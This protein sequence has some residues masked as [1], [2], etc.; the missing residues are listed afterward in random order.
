VPVF[1][2]VFNFLAIRDEVSS[3]QLVREGRQLP[4]SGVEQLEAVLKDHPDDIAMRTKLLGFYFHSALPLYGHDA[5]IEAR[6]GH[7]FWFI[8]HTIPNPRR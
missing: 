2:A 4:K 6:R 3:A 7:I 8:E 1:P 5:T